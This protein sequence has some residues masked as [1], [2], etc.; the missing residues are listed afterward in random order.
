MQSLYPCIEDSAEAGRGASSFARDLLWPLGALALGVALI[1]LA[2]V[3]DMRKDAPHVWRN[4]L[5]APDAAVPDQDADG[6]IPVAVRRLAETGPLGSA[7]FPDNLRSLPEV[8]EAISALGLD[9]GEYVIRV[10]Q[11]APIGM[12]LASGR[13]PDPGRREALAGDLARAETFDLDGETFRV[14]GRVRRSAGCLAFAYVLPEHEGLRGHFASEAGATLGWIDPEGM[15]KAASDETYLAGENAPAVVAGLAR[16]RTSI[17]LLTIA[18]LAC[19]A[20]GG[21]AAQIRWLRRL[22]ARRLPGLAS[23]LRDT[24]ARPRLFASV[25][26]LLYAALF[27]FMLAALRYP[28]AGFRLTGAVHH[29]FAKGDLQYIGAAYASGN[30]LRATA[31]TFFQ[32]YFVATVVFTILPSLVLPFAGVLKN[33]FSFALAGFVIAP[34]WMGSA[35]RLTYHS[36]T[37]ILELEAYIVATFAIIL[38]PVRVFVEAPRGEPGTRIRAAL[39]TVA[40]GTLLAGI[41]LAIAAVYEATTIIF[42]DALSP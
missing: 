42:F 16:T 17:A 15:I 13:L 5:L 3:L 35:E 21:S 24:A 4:A 26:V 25:H 39:R 22:S 10:P 34:I 11:S 18:G 1:S 6:L 30:I 36:I 37:M 23:V 28:V 40:G 27:A 38:W 8:E 20:L 29:E 32:N 14:V 33:L 7:S 2:G 41:M 9:K 31:A 12:L 19:A